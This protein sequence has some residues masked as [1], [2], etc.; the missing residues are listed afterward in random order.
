MRLLEDHLSPQELANLPESPE[1]LASG[2]PD[3][4][5][6]LQHLQQCPVCSSLVQSR[7]KLL[8]LGSSVSSI[9]GNRD[10]PPEMLLLEYA[11]GLRPEQAS[12]LAAHAAS[13]DACA[14]KLLEAMELLQPEKA[15]EVSET[16]AVLS[17]STPEWQRRVAIQMMSTAQLSTATEN[18]PTVPKLAGVQVFPHSRGWAIFSAVAAIL[19]VAVFT[20]VAIW[21][22]VHPSEARLLALAYNQQRTLPLRIPGGNP[23]P[24]A[25]GTRGTNAG[26]IVPV[27]L[28][29]LRL[30][31]QKHLERSPNS[32]YWHQ[33]LGEVNLLE[34]DGPA[35]RRN[36][37]IAQTA[38]DKLP[39]LLPDLA[40]AWFL[41]GQ[42]NGS[43]EAFAEAAELYSKELNVSNRNTSLLLYNR[44]LCWERQG[45]RENALEDLRMALTSEQSVEWRNTIKAEIARLSEQSS[46]G[47]H[48]DPKTESNLVGSGSAGFVANDDYETALA[49]ATEQLLPRWKSEP[50][51]RTELSSLATAGLR[52]RDRWLYDWLNA[53]HTPASEDGDRHLAAAVKDG[54]AGD[55]RASLLESQQAVASYTVAGNLPG[56]ERSL[57]AKIYA[58][59][60]LDRAHECLSAAD[61]LERAPSVKDYAWVRTQLTLEE[62][63]C[64]FL[65]GSYDA[66]QLEFDQAATASAN[67]RLDWLHLRAL[68]AQA[69]ILDFRGT[70]L[71]AWRIDTEALRLCEQIHCPPIREYLLIYNMVHGA[72]N[73][74]LHH[75]AAELMRTGS[76]LAATSG[77]ATTNA[78]AIEK[79]ALIAGRAEDYSTSDRAFAEAANVMSSA[80]PIQTV[81]LYRA[82]WQTDRA[83]VLIRR[84]MPHEAI[85]LLKE[86]EAALLT[87]DYQ[88][89]RLHYFIEMAAAQL[90]IND[91]DGALS[92]ALAGVHETER[93]LHALRSETEREQ[94][95]R[96]N[97][98]AYAQLIKT[99]LKLKQDTKAFET[100][101]YYRYI[102]H[103]SVQDTVATATIPRAH[104][105]GFETTSSSRH[106]LVLALVDQTYVGWLVETQPLRVL[107][108]AVL[109]NHSDLQRTAATFYHLCSDHD[110][111]ITDI[112]VMGARLYV[113][114]LQPLADN[115][116]S[117]NHLW[118]EM[119]P[120]LASIP[121]A[122]LSLPNGT[123]LGATYE[124]KVLPAWWAIRPEIF[125]DDSS[126]RFVSKSVVVDGFEKT[127]G[128]YSEAY[129]V[130]HLLP[131]ATLLEG[132]AATPQNLL[133]NLKSAELFHFSGHAGSEA[134]SSYLLTPATGTSNA[135]LDADELGSLDLHRCKLA[136]LAACNTTASSPTH[137]EPPP[138]LRNALLRSGVHAVVAS[139]WDVDD[140]A[141]GALML[142]FYKQLTQGISPAHS[143][144]LAQI[145]VQSEMTWQHPYY[146]ASFQ[147]FAN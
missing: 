2:R 87:S 121:V 79:L 25:S 24:L 58:L 70:P 130:A 6:I 10:C 3:Q 91:F 77:D 29:E 143:L 30:R 59:Q 7:W 89:G 16:P 128:N 99:Y 32:A 65:S 31:A 133:G 68:G 37:E 119:D 115:I 94:W 112:R 44:A 26:A 67:S 48:K 19:L 117:S 69:Q 138:D 46:T 35:A 51:V 144:Q 43:P 52:H 66:A 100:W 15:G 105:Q 74:G 127:Q 101:E 45:V 106:V 50:D 39:N 36:F 85:D 103:Q 141:T 62:G 11:A 134:Q 80:S 124:I 137:I 4:Q 42:E 131:H 120:S 61:E 78:Y 122:A 96:E 27:A 57:L 64:K 41:L 116:G 63:S 88:G 72:E 23:V 75:V 18:P 8:R 129:E 93:T 132:S 86:N 34:S 113:S 40:A 90:A 95:Q 9:G 82:E 110:S 1:A 114:L 123:W 38:N 5:Q 108:T 14:E 21:R 107:R 126:L 109:G 20:S 136:V 146:W 84:G 47:I 49:K 97:A 55:A 22:N 147:L 17:S 56:R 71:S 28:L 92:S 140:R 102:A 83:E 76:Q 60:R 33:V 53:K 125:S 73:L 12:S 142:V 81:K 104:T 13:C 118:L 135:M 98:L 145:S 139:N 54:S 111:N